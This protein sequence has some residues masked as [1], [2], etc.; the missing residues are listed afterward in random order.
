MTIAYDDNSP[1]S[2]LRLGPSVTFNA[3]GAVATVKCRYRCVKVPNEDGFNG[4]T[5]SSLW[6]RR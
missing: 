5:E 1:H 2:L 4:E 6:R 3:G